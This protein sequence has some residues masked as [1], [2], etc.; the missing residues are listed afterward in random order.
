M[1]KKKQVLWGRVFAF[2]G[3]LLMV[4]VVFMMST[5]MVPST[6][7]IRSMLAPKAAAG[8]KQVK[9][10]S[11]EYYPRY[12]DATSLANQKTAVGSLISNTLAAL[13]TA[14]IPKGYKTAGTPYLLLSNAARI[15]RN[16]SS[17]TVT[18][19]QG[20]VLLSMNAMLNSTSGVPG[21]ISLCDYIINNKIDAVWFWKDVGYDNGGFTEE[22]HNIWSNAL[23]PGQNP[24]FLSCGGKTTFIFYGLDTTRTEAQAIHSMG[25]AF[26]N[27]MYDL[28]GDTLFWTKWAGGTDW[29]SPSKICGNIHFPP[30]GNTG[31]GLGYD[32]GNTTNVTTACPNW[33]PDGTGTKVT[34]NCTI[35]GCSEGGYIKWWFQN[36]PGAAN[37]LTY[38]GKPLPNWWDLFFD[39]EN[40]VSNANKAGQ[41]I[42]PQFAT[43][44]IVTSPTPTPTLTPT[45]TP[46]PSPT[47]NTTISS[48]PVVDIKINNVDRYAANII[49]KT[50]VTL[51]WTTS[52]A[53]SCVGLRGWTGTKALSG[54]FVVSP[55]PTTNTS[56]VLQCKTATGV[57]WYDVAT[58]EYPIVNGIQ[59]QREGK[60][61]VN[62]FDDTLQPAGSGVVGAGA[63]QKGYIKSGTSPKLTWYLWN[64]TTCVP[65]W[66][67]VLPAQPVT[68]PAITAAK[69]YS[70]TCHY[71]TGDIANIYAATANVY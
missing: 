48:R 30:N 56:Y 46:T 51:T 69:S 39:T 68:M 2:V 58:L 28:Q 6:T 32:Y 29:L 11:L 25:H 26:E 45:P 14:S 19:S 64:E 59:I 21:G 22:Y 55:V 41:W 53:A 54:S 70:L 50:G 34:F 31:A 13:S 20:T 4:F 33:K 67:S 52:G 44:K 5:N 42:A 10:V 61:F 27:R 16:G 17:P 35:W 57:T 49:G 18:G 24:A 62:G 47:P 63:Q 23:W 36:I 38:S 9:V 3:I 7:L 66:T 40:G 8:Q 1:A 60:L 37:G 65:S 43:F 15:Q 71:K 12:T